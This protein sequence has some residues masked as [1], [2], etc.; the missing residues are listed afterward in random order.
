VTSREARF[1]R[2]MRVRDER[3]KRAVVALELARANEQRARTELERAIAA[4]KQAEE[5]RRALSVRGAEI[6]EF[7]EAEDWLHSCG[8]AEELGIRRLRQ[9]HGAFE[10]AQLRVKDTRMEVRQ[11][12]QLK[13][14]ARALEATKE[15]RAQR[16]LEDEI[17]QRIVQDQRRPR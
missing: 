6:I 8:V 11:L 3:L 10:K 7:I 1:D 9:A 17:G 15:K 5:D 14:R 13:E 16:V 12:E 2:V 4:R